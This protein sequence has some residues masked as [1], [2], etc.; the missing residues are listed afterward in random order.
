MT[1]FFR[2][3][4][5][6]VAAWSSWAITAQAFAQNALPRT[7]PDYSSW[8]HHG[9]LFLNTTPD[10]ADLPESAVVEQFPVLIRLHKE[11]FDFSQAQPNGEDLRF[12]QSMGESLA[13]QIEFWDV[14]AGTASIWVLVPRI[15]GN[16]RQELRLHWGNSQATSESRGSAVF[17]EA[18]GF[19]SVLHMDHPVQ[20]ATG[21]LELSDRGT[22]AT[23]GIIGSARQLAGG[24]GI[25]CGD[26]I[27]SLPIGADANSTHAWFRPQI[28]NARVLG[29]GNEA[30]QGKVILD[31]RSPASVQM[32]CYFS[33]ANV[34]ST[35]A[36]PLA[37]W[38]HVVHT[39]R[40]GESLLYINGV[41]DAA[42]RSDS[43]PL[44]L[45][46]PSRM[47]IGGWYNDYRFVGDIDEVRIS[48]VVRSQD[49]V[50]LEYENQKPLQTLTGHV[51]QSGDNFTMLPKQATVLE[52]SRATFSVQAQG[53]QKVYWLVRSGEHERVVAT[54]QF[55][56]TFAAGR[57]TNDQTTTLIFKALYADEVKTS[58]CVI[59]IKEELPDPVFSL[60]APSVWNGR[61]TI[62]VT[63][64]VAN[65]VA[66]R[67]KGADEL[68]LQWSTSGLA[69]IEHSAPEKL[70][71]KRSQ[72]SG[73][74]TVTATL[75][76]GGEAVSKNFQIEV[77]EPFQ[78]TWLPRTPAAVEQPVDNQFYARDGNNEGTLC[79]NGT[80]PQPAESVFL[81]LYA[82]DKLLNTELQ[83][84]DGNNSYALS[85]KLK[86]GL[87]KYRIEF[88]S[89]I[90]GTETILHTASNILCG[91]T[92]IIQGQSNALAT[93]THEE[94][95]PETNQWIRSYGNPANDADQNN[96]WCQPVWKARRGE[97][98]E[99]GYWGMELA[100]RLV[101]SR[102]IPLCVFNGAVGGTRIDQHQR[103]ENNPTD[104]GT[105]YGRLLGRIQQAGL[106][107]GIRAVLWHQ[108]ESDQGA[109]GPDGGFGWETYQDYFI[110]MSAAWKQDYPNIQNYYVF[111]IFPN[112]C[113]MGNGNG[114]MLREVQRTLPQLYSNL[115]VIATLGVDPPG[116]CHYP[117][118][119]WAKFADLVQPL[120]E[121]DFDGRRFEQSI[122]SPSFKQARFTTTAND[123]IAI[124]FD[125]PVVWDDSLISEFY[126]D[127]GQSQIESGSASG[128]IV[129]LKLKA[130]STAKKLS[131]L[132]EQSWSQQR[133]LKGKNGLAALTFC[134]V[135]VA[136]AAR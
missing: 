49:W 9:S 4:L 67:D 79:C 11:F 75:S 21:S 25:F 22:T 15:H 19:A 99:L 10:G 7:A 136:E 108:G 5:C 24:Q 27:E 12:S 1:L 74:L 61:D 81:K 37:D 57:V 60:Q 123:E 63:A 129:T 80:L 89:S 105:I 131:Y 94:S 128:N 46:R 116:G 109:D 93:D 53:A 8:T 102:Q 124:Q 17:S 68:K 64:D 107:H 84:P 73:T 87:I 71:L 118:I 47:W 110:A 34:K 23:S 70:I 56:F 28:A 48:N 20:D 3:A 121:R 134:N 66:M 51:V 42:H 135:P 100:K 122:T 114:D 97:P 31:Y 111:Q 126:L 132:K 45:K 106:T 72:N 65:R 78:D 82:D 39:Y 115:D 29:W 55:D 26:M 86:P 35:S 43:A 91:D 40:K 76:N 113:S 127:G 96:R 103:N 2:L 36:V 54:D 38:V 14:D 90:A 6:I 33:S 59:T 32:E 119:G 101:N 85:V 104:L 77:T 41:L 92:Y 120:M 88:G 44:N 18:N 52:G 30:P 117:L 62:E 130:P 112:A 133:I 95:P 58:D 69:T 83:K 50:R 125:Q 16:S 13:Y 98:A